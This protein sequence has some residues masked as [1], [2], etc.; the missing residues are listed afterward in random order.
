V[1][2][3]TRDHAID[4]ALETEILEG[5]VLPLDSASANRQGFPPFF[6]AVS[7][8]AAAFSLRSLV[9]REG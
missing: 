4:S 5:R 8:E 3:E 2:P 9:E 6:P 7:Q 1:L